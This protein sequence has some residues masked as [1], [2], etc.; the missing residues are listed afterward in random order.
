[1]WPTNVIANRTRR[2]LMPPFSMI[3][4]AQM[5]N[6]KVSRMKLLVPSKVFCAAAINGATPL[7]RRNIS[8]PSSI[9]KLTG[10]P[11]ST[12]SR[13]ATSMTPSAAPLP[14]C[15]EGTALIA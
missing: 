9:A 12:A 6:G 4:P 1:M 14:R 13:N 3:R 8:E 5:K 7:I 10:S 2:R 11:S 15:S